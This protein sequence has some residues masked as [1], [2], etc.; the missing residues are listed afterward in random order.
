MEY[1]VRNR[2]IGFRAVFRVAAIAAFLVFPLSSSAQ[3]PAQGVG[4]LMEIFPESPG[5]FEDIT[6]SLKSFSV[7]LDRVNIVWYVNG[8]EEKSGIG[9]KRIRV[10]LGDIGEPTAIRAVIRRGGGGIISTSRT[11][12]PAET[13]ILWQAIG[14]YTPPFYKGKAL[15]ASQAL[16]RAVAIPHFKRGE[17]FRA[18]SDAVYRWQLN[19][20]YR[21]LNN[22]SGYGKRSVL[23]RKNLLLG[24]DDLSVEISDLGNSKFTVGSVFIPTYQPEIIIYENR[25]LL[26]ISYNRAADAD[27]RV[28]AGE[29]SLVAE[30]YFASVVSRGDGAF[31]W[32]GGGGNVN[33]SGAEAIFRAPEEGGGEIS[34]SVSFAHPSRILQFAREGLRILYGD[35]AYE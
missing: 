32:E 1:H 14:V 19:G 29:I 10:T 13:D 11:V 4:V 26:G 5:A 18:D 23:F 33:V 9:Q 22:Q 34:V 28:P 21:T 12:F 35:K 7:D 6:V 15:P 16:I 3:V 20:K 2:R 30:P 31:S 17:P 25:P 27:V 8:K 24:G